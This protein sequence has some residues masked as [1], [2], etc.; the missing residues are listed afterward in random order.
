MDDIKIPGIVGSIVL[1]LFTGMAIIGPIGFMI[2][3]P[4]GSN[5]ENWQHIGAL[6]GIAF[7]LYCHFHHKRERSQTDRSAEK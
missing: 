1:G 5:P 4:I 3:G 2:F 6:I 7:Y